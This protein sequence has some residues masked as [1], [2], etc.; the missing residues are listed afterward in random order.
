MGTSLND[1][2]DDVLEGTKLT[3]RVLLVFQF[4]N[5]GENTW[6]QNAL[7]AYASKLISEK[8]DHGF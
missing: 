6:K 3:D 7:E 4:L 2:I 8:K 5:V 1:W